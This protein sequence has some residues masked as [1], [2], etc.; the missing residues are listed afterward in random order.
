M[1]TVD[2]AVNVVLIETLDGAASARGGFAGVS[3]GFVQHSVRTASDHI[4]TSLSQPEISLLLITA[5]AE[6]L[7]VIRSLLTPLPLPPDLL[8]GV[9]QGTGV[10]GR[11]GI[12]PRVQG[13][14][15]EPWSSMG[16]C[17]GGMDGVGIYTSDSRSSSTEL[18]SLMDTAELALFSLAPI[19]GGAFTLRDGAAEADDKDEEFSS[20]RASDLISI[21]MVLS[22][23]LIS[24]HSSSSEEELSPEVE[25]VL[26]SAPRSD[27][28]S[29][30]SASSICW[31]SMSSLHDV[32]RC[33]CND[34]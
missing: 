30:S 23:L 25:D 15:P 29:S 26:E 32:C 6:G 8:L 14:S 3:T 10:D 24:S 18:I 5:S 13:S 2:E 27:P 34:T 20:I 19:D 21:E 16:S 22:E 9:L 31:S 12:T 17:G 7:L 11:I 4:S 1:F 33:A 28:E